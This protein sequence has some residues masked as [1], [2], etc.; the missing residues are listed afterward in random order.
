MP[1]VSDKH[2]AGKS[3]PTSLSNATPAQIKAAQGEL[4]KVIFNLGLY[5]PR[6]ADENTAPSRQDGDRAIL[7]EQWHEELAQ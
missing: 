3:Q 2:T 4:L 1:S 5:Y 7:G 6:Q